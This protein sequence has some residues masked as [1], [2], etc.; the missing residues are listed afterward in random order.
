[1]SWIY[2]MYSR[3]Y[4][5]S[6]PFFKNGIALCK[7]SMNVKMKKNHILPKWKRPQEKMSSNAW[8]GVL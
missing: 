3:C 5:L 1:M 4:Y 8:F 6:I 2:F 7:Q